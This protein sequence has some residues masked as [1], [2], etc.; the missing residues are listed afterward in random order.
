MTLEIIEAALADLVIPS[1]VSHYDD[2]YVYEHLKRYCS[3]FKPLPSV[4]V[5]CDGN[6]LVLTDRY[7][8]VAIA[9]EFGEDRIRAV[10]QG[11]TFS[12]LKRQGVPGVLG[13]VPNEQLELEIEDEDSA[14]W[15]VL[16]FRTA[17]DHETVTQIE[18][19]FRAFL[20][21]SLPAFLLKG[22][23]AELVVN[24]DATGPCFEIRFRTPVTDHTWAR[25]YLE[26][27]ISI[28]RDLAP[29]ATYQGA[30]F[31]F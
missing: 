29:I 25:A 20:K 16:F 21:Q 8:Y 9:R 12:D 5:T 7:Q 27:L 6:H 4:A 18:A 1:S 22:D 14:C 3:K 30:R 26:F 15:H 28:S 2:N 24:F 23:D 31:G 10:L 19:R 11:V 17:P 13:L